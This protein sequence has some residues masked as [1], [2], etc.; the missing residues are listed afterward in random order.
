MCRLIWIYA[1]CICHT[2][3]HSEACRFCLFVFFFVFFV[4]V[5]LLFFFVD[6]AEELL[7]RV[8]ADNYGII[9]IISP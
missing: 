9:F 8:F 3:F 4:A 5:F 6:T 2:V 7:R 1:G